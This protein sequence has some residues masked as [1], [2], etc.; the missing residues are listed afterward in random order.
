[1]LTAC[2]GAMRSSVIS[3]SKL[4]CASCGERL[5]TQL[6][7]H[8]GID[9]AVFDK[10]KVELRVASREGVDIIG[11]AKPFADEEK[12]DLIEGA[13]KGSYLPA[14]ALPAKGDVKTLVKDGATA[15]DL[16]TVVVK[17]KITVIEFGA[18]WC[19]PCRQLDAHMFAVVKAQTDVAYRKLDVGDWDTPL[20]ARYLR[21]VSSLPY[22]LVYDAKGKRIDAITG[23]NLDRLDVAIA[24]ARAG[25]GGSES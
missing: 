21:K 17:G 2:G 9:T 13:G 20:A 3:L 24:K 19:G 15:P 5:A 23:L 25:A 7:A 8:E 1:M 14:R 18:L 11:L 10:G 12:F 16:D 6:Q 22:V 4:D